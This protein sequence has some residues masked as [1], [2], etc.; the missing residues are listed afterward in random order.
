M[1][2]HLTSGNGGTTAAVGAQAQTAANQDANAA[3][4]AQLPQGAAAIGSAGATQDLAWLDGSQ[5][6]AG[7]DFV[8]DAQDFTAAG[9]A[10]LP[11]GL[12]QMFVAQHVDVLPS[13]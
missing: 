13:D 3:A 6:D 5:S 1:P 4:F 11:Q 8:F 9:S 7:H 12:R 2:A 10:H